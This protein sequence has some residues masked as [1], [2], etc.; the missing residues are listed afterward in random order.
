MF[1]ISEAEAAAIRA[2]LEQR[3]ELFAV[4]EL[5]RLFPG[6]ANNMHARACV[7]AI[8]GWKPVPLARKEDRPSPTKQ[9]PVMQGDRLPRQSPRPHLSDRWGPYEPPEQQRQAPAAVPQQ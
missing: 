4:I 1:V 8:A 6:I 3:G 7:R 9:R 5:R 2:A